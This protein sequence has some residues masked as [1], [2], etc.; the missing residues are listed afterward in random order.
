MTPPAGV[1]IVKLDDDDAPPEGVL[2]VT[3]TEPALETNPEFIVAVKL[4]LLTKLVVS[5]VPF[6]L[7][8]DDETNPLP[9]TVNK[10]EEAPAVTLVGLIEVN[11]GEGLVTVLEGIATFLDVAGE[12]EQ[13]T[14]PE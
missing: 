12:L 9:F 11:T 13:T 2:T 14:L 3:D 1:L 7:I 4:V 6:Q 10:N 8:T 5:A